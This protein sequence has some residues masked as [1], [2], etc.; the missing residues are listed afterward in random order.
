MNMTACVLGDLINVEHQGKCG[1]ENLAK[2]KT[3]DGK[4]SK[5]H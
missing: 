2:R 4:T 1:E 5:L 3:G